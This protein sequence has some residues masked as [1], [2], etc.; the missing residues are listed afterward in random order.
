MEQQVE[1]TAANTKK[2][3]SERTTIAISKHSIDNLHQD[4][5]KRSDHSDLTITL[6]LFEKGMVFA[7]HDYLKQHGMSDR[8]LELT[9]LRHQDYVFAFP[10]DEITSG[11]CPCSDE[12]FLI[13]GEYEVYQWVD[14]VSHPMI[15]CDKCDRRSFICINCKPTIVEEKDM[16]FYTYP[17]LTVNQIVNEEL[18][19]WTWTPELFKAH[20]DEFLKLRSNA[21]ERY[22]EDRR[23]PLEKKQDKFAKKIGLKHTLRD[24]D[25]IDKNPDHEIWKCSAPCDST[26]THDV[27]LPLDMSHNGIFI[28]CKAYCEKCQ[29]VYVCSYWGD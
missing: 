4:Y 15:W 2:S 19:G 18:Y 14:Y 29:M 26:N 22:D 13:S 6:F 20:I 1:T 10:K 28:Y 24:Y 9:E 16:I 27:K 5:S 3:D 8:V 21:G 23:Y 25:E 12:P 17:L 11:T 7:S